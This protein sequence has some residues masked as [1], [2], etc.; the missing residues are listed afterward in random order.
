MGCQEKGVVMGIIRMG[1]GEDE[2]MER[3]EGKGAVTRAIVTARGAVTT[4]L[5]ASVCT[6][7]QRMILL[8]PF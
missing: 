5:F 8:H 6:F 7:W 2:F 1:Y 4:W 3:G